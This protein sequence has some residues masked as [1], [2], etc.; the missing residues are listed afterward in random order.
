VRKKESGEMIGWLLIGIG[1]G[2]IAGV[3]VMSLMVVGKGP[4]NWM[5]DRQ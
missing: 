3:L 4:D 1:I 5:E 2:V